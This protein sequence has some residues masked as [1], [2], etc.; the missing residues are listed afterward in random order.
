MKPSLSTRHAAN[1]FGRKHMK[2]H[3]KPYGCTFPRCNKHFGSKNDWKRHENSQH[4]QLELWKC[5]EKNIGD[6]TE[7]CGNTYNRR[8]QFKTHLSKDHG[9]EDPA[10]VNLKLEDCLDGRNYEVSFWCGF[11]RKMVKVQEK[12]L[13]ACMWVG[14]SNHVDDHF[15]GQNGPKMDISKWKNPE[16][17][18]PE[19]AFV[20]IGP[21][22]E[23][24]HEP[25]G[26][27]SDSLGGIESAEQ[28]LKRLASE[29]MHPPR[30]SK[31]PR[32]SG[33]WYCVSF[34]ESLSRL[35]K[36]NITDLST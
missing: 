26:S 9:I 34:P 33:V 11:C 3:V 13:K 25:S 15:R 6:L 20:L 31:R 30:L 28:P 16:P 24:R 1:G 18:L 5:N 21:E 29:E 23:S 32:V 4:Y 8:E 27:T 19:V 7:L 17:G 12:G 22:E 2:R 14:R 10:T 35:L 36:Y